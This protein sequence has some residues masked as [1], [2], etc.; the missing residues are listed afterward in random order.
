MNW[1]NKNPLF[2]IETSTWRASLFLSLPVL[3]VLAVLLIRCNNGTTGSD[4]T[5]YSA[6]RPHE[7]RGAAWNERVDERIRMVSTQIELRGISDPR[8]LEAMR[9]IPRHFFVP[10]EY[11]ERAYADHPLYI[12]SGQTISQPYIVALMTELMELEGGG[13]VLEIGTGSGYQAAILG[14]LA[15]RVFTIEIIESLA[16]KAKKTLK[17]MK[18]GNITV[19]L[20]DGYRGWP[21]EAPFDA[22][23]VTAAPD[24]IP[25]PLL[26]QLK[27]GG[28]LVLPVGDFYQKLVR[29]T[30]VENGYE[31]E[32]I[33]PVRFVPMTGEA[34]E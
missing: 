13:K 2:L 8:V 3:V 29:I 31:E 15:D 7:A 34:E 33:I 17:D 22:I 4:E 10:P 5:D 30:R 20:G 1:M 32:E 19:R 18:C 27:V 6:V 11:R 26:E 28:C 23:M 9:T 16:E 25:K 24:H 21:S 12:G 14:E